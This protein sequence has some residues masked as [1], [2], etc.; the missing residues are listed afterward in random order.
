MIIP[1]PN[2]SHQVKMG[3][4][5]ELSA[6]HSVQTGTIKSHDITPDRNVALR[7][8]EVPVSYL[9]APLWLFG[10]TQADFFLPDFSIPQ[11][12]K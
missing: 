1:T 10:A 8:H 5:T 7:R 11:L 4:K 12:K 9:E 6:N 3:N 2:R